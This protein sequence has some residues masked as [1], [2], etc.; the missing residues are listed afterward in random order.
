MRRERRRR[1]DFKA[2]YA[3]SNGTNSSK[4]PAKKIAVW[5]SE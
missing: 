1:R 5:K 2:M 4:K 3:S